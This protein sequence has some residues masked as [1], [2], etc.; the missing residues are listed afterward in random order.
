MN[1]VYVLGDRQNNEIQ[2]HFTALSGFEVKNIEPVILSNQ[3]VTS[4]CDTEKFYANYGFRPTKEIVGCALIHQKSYLNILQNQKYEAALILE[5]DA[6]PRQDLNVGEISTVIEKASK[7]LCAE[8]YLLYFDSK[9]K[10]KKNEFITPIKFA[11][12]YAVAYIVNKKACEILLN[13]QKPLRYV[14][15]WPNTGDKIKYYLIQHDF[16]F[17]GSENGTYKSLLNHQENKPD[18][19]FKIKIYSYVWYVKNKNHFGSLKFYF[20][21]MLK[22]R[23]NYHLLIIKKKLRITK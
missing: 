5:D 18:S 17:H 14:A 2:R 8:V 20:D 4:Y 19:C 1:L 23:L 6:I 13:A 7:A 3:Q 15:D 16:F 12:S 9:L 21:S 10:N 22:H 11:P